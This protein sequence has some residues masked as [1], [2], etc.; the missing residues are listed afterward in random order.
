MFLQ[1]SAIIAMAGNG[2][3]ASAVPREDRKLL[4]EIEARQIAVKFLL[5]KY[6]ESKV[7]FTDSQLISKDDVQIY[8]LEGKIT[9][10]SPNKLE[11]LL[12]DKSA[13][14]YAFKIA[15][16]AQHGRVLNHELR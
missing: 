5:A 3:S 12:I 4:T 7:N 10:R 11:W 9:M 1:G 16:D 6:Y 8:H 13:N 15:I 2:A 14:T